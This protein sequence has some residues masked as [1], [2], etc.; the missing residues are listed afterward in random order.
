MD[1]CDNIIKQPWL[2][3]KEGEYL[4]D[5]T[6]IPDK[7]PGLYMIGQLIGGKKEIIYVGRGKNAVRSALCVRCGYGA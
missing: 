1:L 5:T 4:P 3:K 2:E 7:S 6:R